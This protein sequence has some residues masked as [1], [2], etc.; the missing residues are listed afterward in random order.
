M[1]VASGIIRFA[2]FTRGAFRVTVAVL[3]EL[4]ELRRRIT[5]R[6]CAARASDDAQRYF[7]LLLYFDV[8]LGERN[9]EIQI[10]KRSTLLPQAKY[11]VRT[12]A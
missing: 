12:I 5:N 11:F 2:P 4:I 3:R 1:A 6:S 8:A 10:I 7:I 9:I